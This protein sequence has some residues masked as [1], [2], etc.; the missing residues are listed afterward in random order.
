MKI[1]NLTPHMVNVIVDGESI[2]RFPSEGVARAEQTVEHVGELD[3]IE[4]VTMR[5]GK[6]ESLP[7]YTEGVYYIVSI[8]TANAAKAA[9]RRVDDLLIT[10]D[11]VRDDDGRIVGC[12]KF[13]VI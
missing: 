6:P 12:R 7:D 13:A 1:V 3:G 9:G 8:T 10:S 4:L 5:F 11:P 2:K